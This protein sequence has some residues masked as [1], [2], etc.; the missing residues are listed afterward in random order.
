MNSA[1]LLCAYFAMVVSPC[2]VAQ[3]GDLLSIRWIFGLARRRRTH[4]AESFLASFRHERYV[5]AVAAEAAFHAVSEELLAAPQPFVIQNRAVVMDSQSFLEARQRVAARLAQL[6]VA[7]KLRDAAA[8]ER[9]VE[10]SADVDAPAAAGQQSPLGLHIRPRKPEF[11]A[12]Q[13]VAP[14]YAP[15]VFRDLGEVAAALPGNA[16]STQNPEHGP[17]RHKPGESGA[18]EIAA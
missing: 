10:F 5:M 14:E 2:V 11:S 15:L 6:L 3:W 9:V 18:L 8:E 4:A 12:A 17:P 7:Q 13:G 16:R 1:F